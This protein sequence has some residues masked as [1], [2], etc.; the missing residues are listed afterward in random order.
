[1]QIRFR[2]VIKS[3]DVEDPVNLHVHRPLQYVM[4]RAILRRPAVP[5]G[6]PRALLTPNQV[7]LLALAAG[8]G[9]AGLMLSGSPR[10]LVA[11]GGLLFASAI[12][13][14]VDGMVARITKTSSEIGHALDG[15]ADFT[16]NLAT[17][18]AGIFYLAT[19]GW[20]VGAAVLLGVLSHLAHTHH[21]MLYDFHAATYLR[22]LTGGRH[23]GGDRQR[24]EAT[25]DGMRARGASRIARLLMTLF[26]WQLGNR[27]RLIHVVDP[28]H[29]VH[30]PPDADYSTRYVAIER[31][32]MRGW[33][34]LGN[35][36]HVDLLAI[37]AALGR[38]EIY[39]AVR[40]V[41]FTLL[42]LFMSA[43]QRRTSRGL[44]A[45]SPEPVGA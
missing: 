37:C 42:A 15:A 17:T 27:D 28:H 38:F 26:V 8:V 41:G 43:W 24:A 45:S 39:F 35:A 36:P 9:S 32:L 44:R 6:P 7:T 19:N 3:P 25:L 22:H 21:L 10:A 40:I 5:H 4:L 29:D 13:D 18:A 31:P 34:W 2:D 14:G 16:V 20:S 12:L 11:A 23:A 30:G 33:A 1:M